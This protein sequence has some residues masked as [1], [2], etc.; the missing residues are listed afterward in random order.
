GERQCAVGIVAKAIVGQRF[1]KRA[2][3]GELVLRRMNAA[4]QLVDVKAVRGL[5]R[6]RMLDELRGGAYL[7]AARLG[8]RI[9]EEQ[10]ARELD[11]VAHLA[12]KKRVHGHAELLA[13]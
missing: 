2:I 4:L 6:F 9:A 10:V 11:G 7:A 13:D 8:I 1:G 3:A 12:A 5:E